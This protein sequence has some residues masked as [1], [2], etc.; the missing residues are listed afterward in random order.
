MTTF[1]M[2]CA[3]SADDTDAI[4]SGATEMQLNQVVQELISPTNGDCVDWKMITLPAPG[5][6]KIELVLVKRD[7]IFGTE[8]KIYDRFG[9]PVKNQSTVNT[10]TTSQRY[11]TLT[12]VLPLNPLSRVKELAHD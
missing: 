6:I 2:G 8:I 4:R 3:S 1:T 12:A 7:E 10:D 11:I 5:T 9:I